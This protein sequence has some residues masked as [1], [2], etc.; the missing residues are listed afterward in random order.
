MVPLYEPHPDAS[1]TVRFDVFE[2]LVDDVQV[3]VPGLD[4]A[5]VNFAL[6]ILLRLF[7]YKGATGDGPNSAFSGEESDTGD[8]DLEGGG[9]VR[10]E[11]GDEVEL[12]N[13]VRAKMNGSDRDRVR[14]RVEDGET[15]GASTDD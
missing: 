9:G 15:N 4:R 7:M 5:F 14:T 1:D 13:M 11:V 2:P 10:Y 12:A 3:G 6:K 8:G